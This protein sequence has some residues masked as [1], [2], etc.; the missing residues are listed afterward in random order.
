M[1]AKDVIDYADLVIGLSPSLSDV[2][3][4]ACKRFCDEYPHYEVEPK[5]RGRTLYA[6]S[7]DLIALLG[8][9]N[10]EQLSALEQKRLMKKVHSA[11]EQQLVKSL[12]TR[13]QAH[14]RWCLTAL[15]NFD[16][17]RFSE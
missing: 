12:S 17:G 8:Y 1:P 3:E 9:V 5:M 16:W 10:P 11:L 6:N 13:H 14:Y 2:L 15:H 7:T 4:K